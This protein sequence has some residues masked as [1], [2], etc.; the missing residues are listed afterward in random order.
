[1]SRSFSKAL[2]GLFCLLAGASPSQAVPLA[3][4]DCITNNSRTNCAVGEAQLSGSIE[5]FKDQAKLTLSVSGTSPMVVKQVFVESS[6]VTG[7][8]FLGGTGRVDFDLDS[9][10]GNLPGGNQPGISFFTTESFGADSPPPK[11]GI[12]PGESGMFGL[13]LNG[14]FG[15]LAGDLRVGVH[16]IAFAEEDEDKDDKGWYL[17]I[18]E[19]SKIM[20]GVPLDDWDVDGSESFVSGPLTEP[21]PEPSA[22]VTFGVGALIVGFALRRKLFGA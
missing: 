14:D 8:S 21:V 16:V 5:S 6:V 7:G 2:L 4:F 13:T 18:E 1:M 3:D 9:R 22:L 11:D 12:G 20:R 10:P 15:D 19:L 17:S